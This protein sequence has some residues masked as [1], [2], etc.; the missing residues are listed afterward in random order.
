M[1]ALDDLLDFLDAHLG[2]VDHHQQ[3]ALLDGRLEAPQARVRHVDADHRRGPCAEAG[4]RER[5]AH[6][7]PARDREARG[8]KR[9]RDQSGKHAGHAARRRAARERVE[10]VAALRER[11]LRQILERHARPREHVDVPPFDPFQQQFVD[12]ALRALHVGQEEIDAPH[13]APPFGP[14]RSRSGPARSLAQ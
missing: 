8:R 5:H 11:R 14:C 2:N 3:F 1:M 6:H 12:D 10:Q 7:R 9:H 4:A 13:V